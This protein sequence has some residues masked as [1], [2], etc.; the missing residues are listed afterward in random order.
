LVWI[1]TDP[2]SDK[3]KHQRD[4]H[5]FGEDGTKYE[6]QIRYHIVSSAF[7]LESTPSLWIKNKDLPGGIYYIHGGNNDITS[8]RDD[9]KE[10]YCKD[11]EPKIEDLEDQLEQICKGISLSTYRDNKI[12]KIL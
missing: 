6:T 5:A 11:M 2:T 9:I 1:E 4:M 10:R 8:L 7:V 12:S 3:R